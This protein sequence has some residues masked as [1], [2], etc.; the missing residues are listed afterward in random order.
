M[1]RSDKWLPGEH[2]A[3]SCSSKRRY[4]CKTD[5]VRAKLKMKDNPRKRKIADSLTVYHCQ[6]CGGWHLG[7]PQKRR[8]IRE[9]KSP[10]RAAIANQANRTLLG[11]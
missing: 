6:Y 5:A 3:V 8:R 2:K 1:A 9:K 7:R 4:V 10:H 11:E